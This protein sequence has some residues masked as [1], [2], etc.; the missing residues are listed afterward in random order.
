[1]TH[2]HGRHNSATRRPSRLF[3]GQTV[4]RPDRPRARRSPSPR[5]YE[6]LG[7]PQPDEAD[8]RLAGLLAAVSLLGAIAK[9]LW[10]GLGS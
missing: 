4:R 10:S 1:M 8:V 3:P 6:R 7:L 9:A 2:A 5:L